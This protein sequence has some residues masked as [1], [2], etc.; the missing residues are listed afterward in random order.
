MLLTDVA[1]A[2]DVVLSGASWIE[3]DASYVNM[4]GR[5]QAAARAMA[6]PGDA[7]EDWKIFT[8]VGLAL[9]A[10]VAYP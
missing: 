6:P 4:D 2:A 7:Q 9:G 1:K 5:L 3:K 10:A 8:D